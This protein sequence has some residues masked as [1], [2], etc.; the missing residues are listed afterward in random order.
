M[1]RGEEPLYPRCQVVQILSILWGPT[2]VARRELH[3]VLQQPSI[4][5]AHALS[6]EQL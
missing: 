6:G 3:D 2:S 4:L 5:I 1:S